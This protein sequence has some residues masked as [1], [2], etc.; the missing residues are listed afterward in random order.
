VLKL[1]KV[2]AWFKIYISQQSFIFII[3]E[4]AQK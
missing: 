1:E 2:F 3:L 4:A